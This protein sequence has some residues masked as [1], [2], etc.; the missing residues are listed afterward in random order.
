MVNIFIRHRDAMQRPTIA[1]GYDIDFGSLSSGQGLIAGDIEIGAKAVV[2][3][4]NAFQV[5]FDDVDRR[6]RALANQR[7]Q[8]GG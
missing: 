4:F 3:R 1:A 2:E 8:F 6:H 5:G 7:R